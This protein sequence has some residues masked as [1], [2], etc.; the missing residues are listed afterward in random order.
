[1]ADKRAERIAG[2]IK[3]LLVKPGSKVNL[4]R[5]F[6]PGY[7]AAKAE[8]SQAA[9]D[10]HRPQESRGQPARASRGRSRTARQDGAVPTAPRASR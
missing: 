5:D 8:A 10:G 1:M 2:L 4:A 3:P 7:R 9:G 6:D